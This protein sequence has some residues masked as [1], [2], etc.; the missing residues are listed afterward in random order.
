MQTH[1]DVAQW[2]KQIARK[3]AWF[4]LPELPIAVR[5]SLLACRKAAK[6]RTFT[7]D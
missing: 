4:V 5:T 6:P 3:L 7:P 2:I 1:D